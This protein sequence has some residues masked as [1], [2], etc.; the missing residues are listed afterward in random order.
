M[1]VRA[2]SRITISVMKRSPYEN[3]LRIDYRPALG[4]QVR[5]SPCDAACIDSDATAQ[6]Y[7]GMT[8]D[9]QILDL[10]PTRLKEARREQGLSLDAVAKLSGVSRS[11][12]S[13]IER[14]E[15]CS[16]RDFKRN[17]TSQEVIMDQQLVQ[18]R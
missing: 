11:M 7:W 13:Q 14:G 1:A 9:N 5:R 3:L 18:F 12:V 2:P 15:S 17:G 16:S 4:S 10:L 6:Q 8:S